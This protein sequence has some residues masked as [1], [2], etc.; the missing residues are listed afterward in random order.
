MVA[1]AAAIAGFLIG[2][3]LFIFLRSGGIEM[4]SITNAFSVFGGPQEYGLAFGADDVDEIADKF[5]EQHARVHGLYWPG[6]QAMTEVSTCAVRNGWFCGT[7]ELYVAGSY[8]VVRRRDRFLGLLFEGDS[9]EA[10]PLTKL[11]FVEYASKGRNIGF[12]FLCAAIGVGVGAAISELA[13]GAAIGAVVGIAVWWFSGLQHMRFGIQRGFNVVTRVPY[14]LSNP[15][16]MAMDVVKPLFPAELHHELDMDAEPLRTYTGYLA[17][18]GSNLGSGA[19]GALLAIVVIVPRLLLRTFGGSGR[20]DARMRV[21]PHH[22][23]THTNKGIKLLC[24][25]LREGVIYSCFKNLFGYGDTRFIGI[26]RNVPAVRCVMPGVRSAATVG[27]GGVLLGLV[28]MGFTDAVIGGIVAAAFLLIALVMYCQRRST[29][30]IGE[31]EQDGPFFATLGRELHHVEF[32]AA[33]FD[34]DTVVSEIAGI[35][36]ASKQRTLQALQAAAKGV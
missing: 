1:L 18:Q 9:Y 3:L 35:Q 13:V 6:L 22:V 10:F 14:A 25:T 29:I 20:L 11:T 32:R 16:A 31:E 27:I 8:V 15:A 26:L 12:L 30:Y 21:Y 34:A 24:C 19:G 5:L 36:H 23:M 28:L 4:H 33:G 7:H 17:Q 2:F